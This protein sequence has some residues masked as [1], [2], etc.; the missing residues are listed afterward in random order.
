MATTPPGFITGKV[1]KSSAPAKLN[2]AWVAP[3]PMA[4]GKI[5]MAVQ[6]GSLRNSRNACFTGDSI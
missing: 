3:I 4:S 1:R 5:P 6:P 2:I